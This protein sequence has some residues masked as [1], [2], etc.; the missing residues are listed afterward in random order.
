MFLTEYDSCLGMISVQSLASLKRN[1]STRSKTDSNECFSLFQFQLHLFWVTLRRRNHLRYLLACPMNHQVL[2]FRKMIVTLSRSDPKDER[3]IDEPWR[4]F[5]DSSSNVT[6]GIFQERDVSSE[7]LLYRTSKQ[8]W[9]LE[10][11]GDWTKPTFHNT[12]SK[13]KQPSKY[14]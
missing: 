11:G 14:K 4:D 9:C 13:P 7:I 6:S 8:Q 10:G 1:Y 2:V 3:C 5:N 12:D